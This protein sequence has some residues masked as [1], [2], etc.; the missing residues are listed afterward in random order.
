MGQK[1]RK[2]ANFVQLHMQ[3]A[4][5]N[6]IL[7]NLSALKY[8]GFNYVDPIKLDNYSNIQYKLSDNLDTLKHVVSNCNLCSFST[9][10]KNVLFGE[11]DKNANI[12]FLNLAPT[13]LENDTGTSLSGNSGDMLVKMCEN[14]LGVNIDDIYVVNIL[15]CI[16]SKDIIDCEYEINTC[17]P[18]IQKQL[19]IISPKI[20]VAFGDS[21]GYLVGDIKPLE[22]IRGIVQDY[23]GIKIVPTYDSSYILRNPSLKKDVFL[24]LQKVK[25][26][27]DSL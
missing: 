23:N 5:K 8:M 14:V 7:K 26:M 18:Y 15:K 20:I 16:P 11:G 2:R 19:D 24:D 12:I 17:K 13:Q 27:M 6:K 21:L 3:Q 22:Q 4:M 9:N 10:R 1:R 25:L